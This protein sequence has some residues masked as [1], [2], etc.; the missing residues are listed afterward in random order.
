[1]ERLILK[2][3]QVATSFLLRSAFPV[4]SWSMKCP[5]TLAFSLHCLWCDLWGCNFG[6]AT[7]SVPC[8][9]TLE[10]MRPVCSPKP[11]PWLE[12]VTWPCNYIV[13]SGV[14]LG[15][16]LLCF[17][18]AKRNEICFFFFFLFIYMA[19]LGL[20]RGTQDLSVVACRITVFFLFLFS[21]GIWDLVPRPGIKPSSPALEG[22]VLAT[23]WGSTEIYSFFR[24]I[25]WSH[26]SEN[27]DRWENTP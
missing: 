4:L 13:T 27:T 3:G 21:C 23:A 16:S 12:P 14:R 10:P 1:M 11:S 22:R 2:L 26:L 19:L 9:L 5:W 8:V 15:F 17:C 18:L 6:V 20:S 7:G 24:K 25:F